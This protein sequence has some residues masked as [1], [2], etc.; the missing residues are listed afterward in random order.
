MNLAPQASSPL[1]H[2]IVVLLVDDQ[3]II[4]EAVRRI[5]SAADDITYHYCQHATEALQKAVE[6]S[7]TVILQDLVM[8]EIDGL[9]LVPQYRTQAE[10]KDT[11]LIVL[12]T[13]EEAVTKAEAFARGANDYLVKIPDGLE[14]IA[15]IRYHSRG[16]IAM[17]ERQAAY[18]ALQRS[19][20]ILRDQLDSAADYVISL[21]P[22]P[23]KSPISIDW[24]FVPSAALGGDAFDYQWLDDQRLAMCLLD[25]CGHGVGSALLSVS[26]LNT[27]RSRTLPDTNFKDPSSVLMRVN[28]AFQMDRQN[29]LFFTMWYGVYD[30]ETRQ[31]T[32]AGAAHPPALLIAPDETDHERLREL[33]SS[34]PMIGI[35]ED[36]TFPSQ[37]S[38]VRPGDQLYFFSDGVFEIIKPDGTMWTMEEFLEFMKQPIA[39][40]TTK[41]E[42]L[43]TYVRALQGRDELNDDFSIVHADF[44][45][46]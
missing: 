1:E 7:P 8:P 38:E 35:D 31:L 33:N 29:D 44:V 2:K 9:D 11:P 30:C 25:V 45:A 12:S 42:E 27:L 22:P 17:L 16:Y 36:S 18:E 32:H 4:G 23:M 19:E 46:N 10:T 6:L 39:D 15:R 41:S 14:L 40:G 26:V 3:P 21:L 13:K 43:L 20:G 24:S 34:G 28:Q 37:T 5:L